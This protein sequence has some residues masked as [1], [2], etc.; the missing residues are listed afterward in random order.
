M[1]LL[2]TA[3]VCLGCVA[4]TALSAENDAEQGFVQLFDGKTLDGWAGDTK[5]YVAE[6]GAI[7]CKPGGNLYTEK[8]Y[9]DFI[10]RFEFKLPPGANNGV[11][12]RTPRNVNAAYSGMEIQILDDGHEK[13]AGWLQDYQVHGSIYGVAPA[14]RGHLKPAGEWNTE[15]ILADGPHVK[16]TLNGVVIVDADLDEVEPLDHQEH[17]GLDYEAGRISLHAHGNYGAEVFFRNIRVK[18][19]P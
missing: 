17:P 7:K 5:G 6:D 4:G 15:E 19:L 13:Y 14:K 9:G 3:I 12:I 10:F 2:M 18:E 11:G 1:R 16:V 8:E